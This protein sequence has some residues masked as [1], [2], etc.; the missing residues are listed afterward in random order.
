M[1][2]PFLVTVPEDGVTEALTLTEVSFNGKAEDWEFVPPHRL[3]T[4]INSSLKLLSINLTAFSHSSCFLGFIL[5][6]FWQLPP[7]SL[8][9]H[10]SVSKA[11]PSL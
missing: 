1:R 8:H 2:H 7:V 9:L 10:K 11:G 3:Q 6:A 5:F 4:R